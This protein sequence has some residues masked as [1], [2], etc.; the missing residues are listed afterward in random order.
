MLAS[1]VL[2]GKYAKWQINQAACNLYARG[3]WPELG[4]G[5]NVDM[6]GIYNKLRQ[7]MQDAYEETPLHFKCEEKE[8]EIQI[9]CDVKYLHSSVCPGSTE[10][11]ASELRTK[12]YL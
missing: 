11:T 12:G 5:K 9:R 4:H 3:N 6:M 1:K 10:N 2:Q 8:L 7:S